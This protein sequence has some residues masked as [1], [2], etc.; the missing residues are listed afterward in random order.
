MDA[1]ANALAGDDL[2]PL[3]IDRHRQNF[4]A[5]LDDGAFDTA[6]GIRLD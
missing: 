3:A 6:A 2:H 4:S 1:R 5:S